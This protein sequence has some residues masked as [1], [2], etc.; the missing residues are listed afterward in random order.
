MAGQPYRIDVP[1]SILEDLRSRL[2]RTRFARGLNGAGWDY[3]TSVSFLEDLCGYW[4]RGFDWR[5]QESRLNSFRQFR[6]DVDGVGLHFIH[7]RGAGDD[8]I[9]L[10]LLHGWPDSFV[11]FLKVIP[12]LTRPGRTVRR[13]SRRSMS[14]SR[15]CRASA[16]RIDRR[17]PA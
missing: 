15:A 8:P 14:S 10:L 7:E 9:P 1:D 12:L 13:G 11:R 2:A 17:E 16:S 3:G 4:R 5:A 6:A